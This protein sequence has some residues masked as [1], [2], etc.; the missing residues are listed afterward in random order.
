[1]GLLSNISGA[2]NNYT[3]SGGSSPS[4]VLPKQEDKIV[5]ASPTG[6]RREVYPSQAPGFYSSGW[7]PLSDYIKWQRGEISQPVIEKKIENRM[8]VYN[9]EEAYKQGKIT[10]DEYYYMNGRYP[11]EQDGDQMITV[12]SPSGES[13]QI[14]ASQ[15]P[16]FQNSGWTVSQATTSPQQNGSTYSTEFENYWK[17]VSPTFEK[18]DT[19]KAQMWEQWQTMGP[20]TTGN[21]IIDS[22][23]DQITPEQLAT[24]NYKWSDTL[25]NEAKKMAEADFGP[26]YTRMY[27]T[28]ESNLKSGLSQYQQ[29]YERD[30]TDT[31][32]QKEQLK[33]EYESTLQNAR[34]SYASS[35]LAYSSERT[36]K[37]SE[38]AGSLTRGLTAQ[39]TSLGRTKED[40][41]AAQ[42]ELLAKGEMRLG[43]STTDKLG[44]QYQ[45]K[46]PLSER[47]SGE[48]ELEK[49]KAIAEDIQRQKANYL[50]SYV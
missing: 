17:N 30:V 44:T 18:N 50:Q 19:T 37:E 11:L 20:P 9:A 27:E 12:V 10:K 15:A 42:Q 46:S 29:K 24:T 39:E 49:R 43:T 40:V 2:L 23:L 28:E 1:M 32:L 14:R 36:G 34:R 45:Y 48:L 16:G 7:M 31:E 4:P 33:R 35:G 3:Q 26:Y 22:I 5:I 38:L 47:Y 21:K 41:A 8:P 6:E 13:R 25:Q